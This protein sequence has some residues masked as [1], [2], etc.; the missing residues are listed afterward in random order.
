MNG[1]HDAA[2]FGQILKMAWL[3]G[4]RRKGVIGTI[5]PEPAN[6]QAS[7]FFHGKRAEISISRLYCRR[8]EPTCKGIVMS[9]EANPED[10]VK[11]VFVFA[12]NLSGRHTA[13]DALTALRKHGATYGRAVGLQ[14][15]SY[16]IPVRDEKD[17]LL[18]VPVIARYVQ[19]FLRFAAIHKELIFHV[20]PIACRSEEH[21]D[22]Q[23][24]PLFVGA[25]A[26]CRLPR[27]WQRYLKGK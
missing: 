8:S 5:R 21:R 9:M 26:N 3:T 18:P 14:G 23:I 7:L 12:S 15:R 6:G 13:G 4:S 20:T 16:A 27:K 1:D 24:A 17:K 10:P 22:E 25:P 11:E 19:A 2:P